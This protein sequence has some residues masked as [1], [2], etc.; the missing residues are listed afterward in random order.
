MRRSSIAQLFNFSIV[1]NYGRPAFLPASRESQGLKPAFF[2]ATYTALK[3]LSS[4][5][6]YA[7]LL[8]PLA[9]KVLSV[10]V[11]LPTL[12]LICL[13]LASAFLGNAIFSTPL[14]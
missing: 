14:S 3:R 5:N 13:G 4:T 1:K 2:I 12:T 10:L 8:G 6:T 9:S 7:A 11:A